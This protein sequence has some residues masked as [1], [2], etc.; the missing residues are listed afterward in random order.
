MT[1]ITRLPETLAAARAGML[2]ELIAPAS[3]GDLN[4]LEAVVATRR[5]ADNALVT[6]SVGNAA[7]P[8]GQAPKPTAPGAPPAQLSTTARVITALL[9]QAGG[10]AAPVQGSTPLWTGARTP[11][12][13]QLAATLAQTVAVSG[14]F[15]ESHLSD[16]ALAVRSVA[17]LRLEPQARL[18]PGLQA[19]SA[20][21]VG[22]MTTA[23]TVPLAAKTW[24]APTAGTVVDA[25]A[26]APV[27]TPES[28]RL[29]A[30]YGQ[31]PVP[32]DAHAAALGA[33]RLD[34][35]GDAGF[36]S[37]PAVQTA[38][39][40]A[41][42]TVTSPATD[43]APL[44]AIPI[45]HPQ[46]VTL[47]NQQL[48]LLATQVFR[49]QGEAWPGVPMDWS[50]QPEDDP[51]RSREAQEPVEERRWSTQLSLALPA[52]G[53]VDVQLALAGQRLHATVRVHEALSIARCREGVDALQR[54]L[55]A[56]GFEVQSLQVEAAGP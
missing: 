54:R 28:A 7:L 33:A 30:M 18:S 9:A 38:N 44:P 19:A 11:A 14:L 55:A 12:V 40:N 34:R 50:V 21:A 49:W 16:L 5:V 45:V 3:G 22:G 51:R 17:E 35:A 20:A 46:A 41:N 10:D 8:D 25:A 2:A 48:D 47:V 26:P 43:T 42:A 13:P 32:I 39:A 1:A 24:Q 52:M 37:A 36:A 4:P 56:A 29:R 15:Y 53:A 6:G 23:S 31:P 27:P